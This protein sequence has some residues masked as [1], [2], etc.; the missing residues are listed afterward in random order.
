M[1]TAESLERQRIEMAARA[2]ELTETRKNLKAEWAKIESA[3]SKLTEAK[4]RLAA[5]RAELTA[6]KEELRQ[7]RFEIVTSDPTPLAEF[8]VMAAEPI[9]ATP[10]DFDILE[11]TRHN[12]VFAAE[13][14]GDTLVVIPLG[15]A[16]DFH[17]G[18][19]QTESNKV[20]RL[21]E[22]GNF[23][24]LVVDLGSAPIFTAVTLNV[25]VV[26][27][28]IV[29]N[30]G[31]KAVLCEATEKTR[32]VLQTMKLLELWPSFATRDEAIRNLSGGAL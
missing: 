2:S 20:R 14:V 30:R 12:K 27:S 28:R 11:S 6:L 7:R 19:V 24:N 16:T 25:V 10:E 21:L 23:K 8:D 4:E 17:Y 26:L 9:A 31:G 5:Q 3:R 18:D 32:G 29:S 13:R 1:E 15:D 22:G